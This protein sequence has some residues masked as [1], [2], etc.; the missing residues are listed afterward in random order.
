MALLTLKFSIFHLSIPACRLQ[1]ASICLCSRYVINY[2][3]GMGG[4]RKECVTT[5]FYMIQQQCIFIDVGLKG[6]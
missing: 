1:A 5:E 6:G 2:L 3:H 4:T